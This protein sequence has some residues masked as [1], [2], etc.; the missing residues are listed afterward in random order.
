MLVR[1]FVVCA[2]VSP[3]MAG[4]AP[5]AHV[6]KAYSTLSWETIR[7][8]R[9][10]GESATAFICGDDLA[11]KATVMGLSSELGLDVADVGPLAETARLEM[12]VLLY[13]ALARSYGRNI[14]FKLLRR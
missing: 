7:D 12:M 9:F 10:G 2:R 6:V 8:P 1:V 14:A 13:I 4:R 11:A 5:D 3:S